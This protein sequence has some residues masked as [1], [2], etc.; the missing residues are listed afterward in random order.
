MQSWPLA[1]WPDGSL[2]CTGHAIGADRTAPGYRLT[3]GTPA[4]P[5]DPVTVRRDGADL[6]LANGMLELRLATRGDVVPGMVGPPLSLKKT[7]TV[8]CSRP[9]SRSVS[10]TR[11]TPSS[12][13]ESIAAYVRRA[14][15]WIAENR[16]SLGSVAC[17][18]VCTALNAR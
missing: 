18:G 7:T 11:P 16:A 8:F 12:M 10:R 3:P 2:K 13:A 14:E 1:Y 15:S 9:R 5:Q 4:T 17:I 6:V